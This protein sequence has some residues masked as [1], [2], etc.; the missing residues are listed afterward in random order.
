MAT[1]RLDIPKFDRLAARQGLKNH[2]EII[3]AAGIGKRTFA[4]ARA[5]GRLRPDTLIELARA[6]GLGANYYEL[7]LVEAHT[8]VTVRERLIPEILGSGF[9][10][11][12]DRQ[13]VKLVLESL[14]LSDSLLARRGMPTFAECLKATSVWTPVNDSHKDHP[15][16]RGHKYNHFV[17]PSVVVTLDLKEPARVLA[18]SRVKRSRQP[19]NVHTD[20][21]SIL[22]GASPLWNVD[23]HEPS[24]LDHW[25]AIADTRRGAKALLA[26]TSPALLQM[27]RYKID[28]LRYECRIR[29]LGVITKDER[30]QGHKRV[31]TQFVF[32]VAV[33]VPTKSV[34]DFLHGIPGQGLYRVSETIN[35]ETT[36]VN[37][38][39]KP[40]VMDVIAW[41]A[42]HGRAES[43]AFGAGK[44]RR[45]F[46]IA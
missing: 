3:E 15:C 7:V 5:G 44:F 29:P 12:K 26:G 38:E 40:N 33:K 37:E 31:Y 45:D 21:L 11:H 20:G 4:K 42:L 19:S 10:T 1:H 16:L 14:D 39:G 36:F 43:F 24:S 23:R 28:L 46:L 34:D 9:P 6:V 13:D 35:P 17:Q 22:F 27:V 41:Q 18:Y 8:E 25:L 2:Q 30:R 32:H